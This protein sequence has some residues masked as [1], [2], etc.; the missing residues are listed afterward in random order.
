MA[1]NDWIKN[2]GEKLRDAVERAFPPAPQ[3]QRV[4]VRIPVVT[5]RPTRRPY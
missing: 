5:P 3:P 1:L 2:A 4:P